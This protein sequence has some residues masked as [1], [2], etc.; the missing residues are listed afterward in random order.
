MEFISTFFLPQNSIITCN[1]IQGRRNFFRQQRRRRF[2]LQR[3]WIV[4]VLCRCSDSNTLCPLTNQTTSHK[5]KTPPMVTADTLDCRVQLE[6]VLALLTSSSTSPSN[7]FSSGSATVETGI[8][9]ESAS[10]SEF[11][12]SAEFGLM[13]TGFEEGCTDG[14]S[15]E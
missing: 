5:Q 9:S 14:E 10:S 11:E 13:V 3:D 2:R 1:F 12:G 7:D 8:N 15:K 4:T 6:L